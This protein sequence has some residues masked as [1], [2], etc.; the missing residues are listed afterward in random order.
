MKCI[1]WLIFFPTQLILPKQTINKLKINDNILPLS[2][3]VNQNV[4]KLKHAGRT[5]PVQ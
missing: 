1:V 3:D 5:L 4:N 2:H